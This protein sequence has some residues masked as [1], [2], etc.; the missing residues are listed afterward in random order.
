MRE[1]HGQTKIKTTMYLMLYSIIITIISESLVGI[2]GGG[3]GL[4]GATRGGG[5]GVGIGATC[6]IYYRIY[7]NNSRTSNSS[8]PRIVAALSACAEK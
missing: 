5:V 8:R 7:S 4:V 3:G 2:G 1:D 6:Y